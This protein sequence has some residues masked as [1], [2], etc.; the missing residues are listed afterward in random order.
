MTYYS[1][2]PTSDELYHYGIKGMRWGVRRYENEDG[3]LTEAGKKRYGTVEN[4]RKKRRRKRI[5]VGVAATAAAAAA[6]FSGNKAHKKALNNKKLQEIAK[7]QK[8]VYENPILNKKRNKLVRW[9]IL[10]D[11]AYDSKKDEIEKD[12]SKGKISRKQYY[13]KHRLLDEKKERIHNRI[14]KSFSNT[15][16]LKNPGIRRKKHD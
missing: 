12:Y 7:R 13:N 9:D 14:Y 6:L 16:D 4:Y 3:T 1:T 5:A 10:L 15:Y 8:E 2:P 11:K